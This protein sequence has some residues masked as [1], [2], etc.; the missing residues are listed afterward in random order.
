MWTKEEIEAAKL[1]EEELKS[2]LYSDK[3]ENELVEKL[4]KKSNGHNF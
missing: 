3:N 4:R 2:W 1:V